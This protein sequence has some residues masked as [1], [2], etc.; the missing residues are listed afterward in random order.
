MINSS[1]EVPGNHPCL[2]G[3]FPGRPIVPGVVALDLMSEGLLRE[4]GDA[5]ICGFSQIK[6]HAPIFPEQKV[7]T[8]FVRKKDSLYDFTCEV[9]GIRVISGKIRLASNGCKNG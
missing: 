2:E 5:Y 3:H 9:D 7:I 8:Q 4:L 6:F 1:F